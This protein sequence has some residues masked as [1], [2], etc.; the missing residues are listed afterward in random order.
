LLILKEDRRDSIAEEGTSKIEQTSQK[1][2]KED[3]DKSIKEI[4]SP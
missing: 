1:K 4:G 2:T 3:G